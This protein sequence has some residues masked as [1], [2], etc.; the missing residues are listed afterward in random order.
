MKMLFQILVLGLLSTGARADSV[1]SIYDGSTFQL[2][3]FQLLQS[4]DNAS[5]YYYV[6]SIITPVRT[7]RVERDEFE[8]SRIIDTS[9]FAHA[10]EERAD[11]G[12]ESVYRFEAQFPKP[13][14]IALL[15]AE[16]ALEN[17]HPGASIIG[18]APVCGLKLAVPSISTS[19]GASNAQEE[20]GLRVVFGIATTL[21]GDECR[22]SIALDRFPVEIRAPLTLEPSLARALTGGTGLPLNTLE[23]RIPMKYSDHFTGRIQVR[24]TL[25]ALKE[26]ENI[27]GSLFFVSTQ[28]QEE[29]KRIVDRLTVTGSIHLDI[30]SNQPETRTYFRNM[31]MEYLRETFL[32]FAAH[33]LTQA[34]NAASMEA[35]CNPASSTGPGPS[36]VPNVLPPQVKS[37]TDITPPISGVASLVPGQEPKIPACVRVSLLM[38][39]TEVDDSRE[40]NLDYSEMNYST[41]RV[42]LLFQASGLPVDRLD[43]IV[44]RMLR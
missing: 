29:L 22:S 24:R 13:G 34:G 43:P 36:S 32:K 15:Q 9:P 2:R 42:P 18:P 41:L 40:F 27:S 26:L 23:L 37:P 44:R 11:G 10:I 30:Q 39:E 35:A 31:V 12:K 14:R 38:S 20:R 25:R 6:P 16:Q 17:R 28:V 21:D 33:P 1:A 5:Q 7:S 4:H 19:S 3:G 8:N